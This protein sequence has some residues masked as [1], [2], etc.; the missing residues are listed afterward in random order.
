MNESF[1]QGLGRHP[2]DL[3]FA[4]LCWDILRGS[5]QR[6]LASSEILV[7]QKS[8]KSDGMMEGP[9]L[10]LLQLLAR[11]PEEKKQG[12]NHFI[13]PSNPINR[14]PDPL[15]RHRCRH[16]ALSLPLPQD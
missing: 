1:A 3:C 11:P 16:P 7:L 10:W 5:V 15:R 9:F 2:V 4:E 13:V 12:D 6:V 8:I 14:S